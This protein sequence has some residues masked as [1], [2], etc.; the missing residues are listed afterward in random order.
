M[1]LGIEGGK[2]QGGTTGD[3]FITEKQRQKSLSKIYKYFRKTL[4]E[5]QEEFSISFAFCYLGLY[6]N[7][8]IDYSTNECIPGKH[9]SY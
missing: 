8:I 3:H 4:K 1:S 5:A 9:D 7:K 2:V 6:D